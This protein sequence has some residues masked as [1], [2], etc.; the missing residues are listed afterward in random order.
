MKWITILIQSIAGFRCMKVGVRFLHYWGKSY[1]TMTLCLRFC[2]TFNCTNDVMTL[3]EV[4][5]DYILIHRV[6]N[7]N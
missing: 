7:L 6:R 4:L 5:R 3:F 1:Q 2:P